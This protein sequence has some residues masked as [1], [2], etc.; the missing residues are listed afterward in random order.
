MKLAEI[1]FYNP[2]TFEHGPPFDLFKEFRETKPVYWNAQEE[3]TGFWVITRYDDVVATSQ[4]YDSYLSGHGVFVDDSVGGSELMLVNMDAPKHSGLRNLVNKGFT[5][6]MIR[7]MEP[8][9]R[10]IAAAIIDNIA[11]KGDCDF[12]TEVAAELPLQGIAEHPEAFNEVV[13][14]FVERS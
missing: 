6:K 11:K 8:H 13:R 9:V 1:D 4:D 14:S 7:R 2:D 12:V 10:D 5:P 3:G